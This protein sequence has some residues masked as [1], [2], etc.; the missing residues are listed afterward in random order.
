MWSMSEQP[1]SETTTPWVVDAEAS[2]E[3]KA[4]AHARVE[5]FMARQRERERTA[6]AA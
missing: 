1:Q 2:A 5:A 3:D 4:V 6:S